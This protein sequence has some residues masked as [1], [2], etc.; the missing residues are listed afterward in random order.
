MSEINDNF[1]IDSTSHA[2]AFQA[3]NIGKKNSPVVA[4]TRTVKIVLLLQE[5]KSILHE[6]SL[7]ILI[8]YSVSYHM[9]NICGRKTPRDLEED[10]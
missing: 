3:I 5:T 6:K 10:E 4:S 9:L 2:A 8:T 7:L 1:D